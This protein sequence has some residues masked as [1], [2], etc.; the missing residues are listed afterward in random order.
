VHINNH[1]ITQRE[2]AKLLGIDEALVSKFVHYRFDEFTL[3]RLI[4]YLLIL[5]PNADVDFMFNDRQ[6]RSL[7][8]A[9]K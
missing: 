7:A 2:L 6:K 9:S 3:D 1:K 5:F 8:R 4:G